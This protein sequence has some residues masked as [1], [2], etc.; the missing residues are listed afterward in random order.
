M[1]AVLTHDRYEP[2]VLKLPDD[3]G[4]VVVPEPGIE[5]PRDVGIVPPVHGHLWNLNKNSAKYLLKLKN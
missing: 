1:L 5:E 4:P 3:A 2:V